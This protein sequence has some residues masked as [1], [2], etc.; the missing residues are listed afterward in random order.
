VVSYNLAVADRDPGEMDRVD[1][2]FARAMA[3]DNVV[4]L[5]AD[6]RAR[7]QAAPAV[8]L[9]SLPR[10]AGDTARAGDADTS[11]DNFAAPGVNRR[12]I[13]R[14]KR[15]DYAAADSH[16]LHGLTAD[17]ACASV[18]QFLDTSRHH[19]H[20]CVCIVH[21]RGLH[22]PGG[23]AVLKARVRA[24]LRSHPAVLA[25]SDAPASDGSAGAV[26]I[27]LRRPQG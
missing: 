25:Y 2:D 7:V 23:V 16:D 12:E 13:K 22:S 24:Y 14:L 26:Y 11:D 21:G 6:E 5:R 10:E 27:L 17:A 1:E 3:A 4:P 15:G 20:R 19:R 18:K 9:P 8:S